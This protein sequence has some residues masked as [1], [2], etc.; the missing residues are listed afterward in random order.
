MNTN[1]IIEATCS[2]CGA[3]A[4]THPD[5]ASPLNYCGDCGKVVCSACCTA[6]PATRCPACVK[7]NAGLCDTIGCALTF[8]HGGKCGTYFE[9]ARA[10]QQL[11]VTLGYAKPAG[12][13]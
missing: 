2:S 11:G 3:Q 9:L 7:A 6:D 4:S 13:Q 5:A 1:D 8:G 12:V 10:C